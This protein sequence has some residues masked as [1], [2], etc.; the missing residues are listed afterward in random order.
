MKRLLL[1]TTMLLVCGTTAT[2]YAQT[3]RPAPV[4]PGARPT[5]KP[6]VLPKT[7]PVPPPQPPKTTTTVPVPASTKIEPPAAPLE[8][9]D[10]NDTNYYPYGKLMRRDSTK[11]GILWNLS[12]DAQLSHKDVKFLSETVLYNEDTRIASAPMR[13]RIEDPQNT[14]TGNSGVAYYKKEL[15]YADLAGDVKIIARPKQDDPKATVK[16]LRKEFKSPVT[17]TCDKLR[18][19]WKQKR[20]F[21]DTNVK[22]T[23]TH[24][25]KNWTIT[26]G[27]L[28][29][30]GDTERAL[31]KGDV[32]AVN[33]KGERILSDTA[34]ITLKEG[35]EKLITQPVKVGTV[36]KGDP[37]DDDG[38]L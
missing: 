33:D 16:S 20:A 37:D 23:F 32:V 17:I 35:D 11:Q 15:R 18:Y 24:K 28:E 12:G 30:F 21:T 2:L 8:P 5:V 3:K 29:Y 34:D 13:L 4:K 31:I 6:V 25:D 38:M 14:L 27:S 9:K 1:A 26:G 22:I 10:S 7:A 36:I 19:W